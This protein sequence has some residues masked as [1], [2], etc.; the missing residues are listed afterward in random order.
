MIAMDQIRASLK[1]WLNVCFGSDNGRL[2]IA[3]CS[4]LVRQPHPFD[5]LLRQTPR[6]EVIG[7]V[8]TRCT[9]SS[10]HRHTQQP[11]AQPDALG[12]V[13]GVDVGHGEIQARAVPPCC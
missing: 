8:K 10:F 1:I 3:T 7:V 12:G 9:D 13:F 5:T 4:W 2:N 6:Y 11:K